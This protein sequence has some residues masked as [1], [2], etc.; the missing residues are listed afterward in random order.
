MNKRAL[1]TGVSGTE[2][3]AAG[4]AFVRAECRRDTVFF[5]ISF[6]TPIQ[7][8]LPVGELAG[9]RSAGTDLSGLS[10]PVDGV[11]DP[12]H[13]VTTSATMMAQ[14]IR[15]AIGFQGLLM[16]SDVPMKAPAGSIGGR[17][18]ATFAAGA[19]LH[20]NE[21]AQRNALTATTASA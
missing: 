19:P 18:R 7:V 1:D 11:A 15:S 20:S 21:N 13:P 16:S 2:L 10:I 8:A 14:V 3:I 9:R 6:G 12:L 17:N 5:R 4:R